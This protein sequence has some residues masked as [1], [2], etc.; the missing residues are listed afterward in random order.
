M[1]TFGGMVR[2]ATVGLVAGLLAATSSGGTATAAAVPCVQTYSAAY[3]GPPLIGPDAEAITVEIFSGAAL[4]ESA[5]VA[6]VDARVVVDDVNETTKFELM[7]G[8]AYQADLAIFPEVT[9]FPLDVDLTFDDEASQ[10][11]AA[12]QNFG[13]V[14]PKDALSLF[15]GK[16]IS[17]PA[18]MKWQL[19]VQNFSDAPV[20]PRSVSLTFT[21][22]SCDS[23]GDGVEEKAD[24]C[25]TVANA[26]QTNWDGDAQGN[27]CDATPGS[28]PVTPTPTPTPTT[29]VTATPTAP[30]PTSIPVCTTGC[31]YPR[32]V[33]LRHRAEQHRLVGKVESV[34]LGCHRAVPV[35]IWRK[36][37]GVD[38]KLVVVTT[39][40]TGVFRTKAPRRPGRFYAAVGS[41]AEPMCGS[42][43][44]RTVRVRR[45]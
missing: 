5:L 42:D 45:R 7:R 40:A 21:L 4:P 31:A 35:T 44:S 16:T 22:A 10:P 23:D 28:A 41:A 12:W 24:N 3:A 9:T 30:Q 26:D 19:V 17:H 25:P 11:R 34:A 29:T 39:R 36:R 6:D 2:L 14:R 15:D 18:G 20:M 32:T 37:S 33:G 43:R 1:V 8:A 38:R 27:A 13:A